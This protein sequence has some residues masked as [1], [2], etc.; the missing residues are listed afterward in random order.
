MLSQKLFLGSELNENVSKFWKKTFSEI[1]YQKLQ[2]KN[3]RGFS[4][5][6]TKAISWERVER[7]CF[8]IFKKNFFWNFVPKVAEKNR[9]DFSYAV[10]KAISWERAEQKCFLFFKKNFFWNFVP[11]VVEKKSSRLFVRRHESY[12]SGA[13]W[14]KKCVGFKNV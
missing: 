13:S 12:F 8:E 4:Y 1:L 7:K 11:K 14:S 6:F 5:A 10:M 2:K 9:L 3:R